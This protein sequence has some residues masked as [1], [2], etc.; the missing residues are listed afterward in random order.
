[1]FAGPNGS[2]KSTIKDLSDFK[3]EWLANQVNPDEMLRSIQAT[4][5]L[6]L[7]TFQLDLAASDVN[8]WFAGSRHWAAIESNLNLRCRAVGGGEVEFT[9]GTPDAYYMSW[10][11]HEIRERLIT[12]QKNFTT[13]T[14]MSHAS[15]IGLIE[16]TRRLGYRN[17]LY[18]VCVDSAD[19]CV[20]RV[21]QRV[22]RGG[23][24]VPAEKIRARYAR[25]LELLPKALAL[26][27]RAYLFDNSAE[28]PRLIAEK[29]PDGS[30]ISSAGIVPHPY[31]EALGKK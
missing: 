7:S 4:G 12:R 20:R 30:F 2:G 6:C 19:I 9:G 31:A 28:K 13:E 11:A 8:D 16:R 26:S 29:L 5:R 23:H 3:A 24:D 15:K 18:Y 17:Y 10:L 22:L 27:Y 21:R 14:V 1:M 25:S